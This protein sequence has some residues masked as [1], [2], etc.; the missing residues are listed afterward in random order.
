MS[1]FK[2]S[3]FNSSNSCMG[4]AAITHSW[5]ARSL[6]VMSQPGGVSLALASRMERI[7]LILRGEGGSAGGRKETVSNSK[8]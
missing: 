6:I 4:K 2:V 7:N 8:L 1:H 5:C 3:F